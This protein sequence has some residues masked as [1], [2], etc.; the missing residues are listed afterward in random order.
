LWLLAKCSPAIRFTSLHYVFAAVRFRTGR[1]APG[2]CQKH[3]TL[4]A[5][6]DQSGSGS[7]PEVTE[8]GTE[9]RQKKWT[10]HFQKTAITKESARAKPNLRSFPS[11]RPF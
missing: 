11:L 3:L 10:A 7:S 2:M 9:A 8:S 1:L 5:K 6:P 4:V